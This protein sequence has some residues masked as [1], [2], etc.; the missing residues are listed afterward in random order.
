MKELTFYLQN[1][2]AIPAAGSG[3]PSPAQMGSKVLLLAHRIKKWGEMGRMM[4][5]QQRNHTKLKEKERT[6]LLS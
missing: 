6:N 3:D 2:A 5:D 1:P 4:G